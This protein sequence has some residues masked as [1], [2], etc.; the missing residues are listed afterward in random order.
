MN[1]FIY[2]L[3]GLIK[4]DAGRDWLIS[5]LRN[6]KVA[7]MDKFWDDTFARFLLTLHS[8]PFPK[9]GIILGKER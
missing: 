8:P 7:T 3:P 4:G 9:S 2:V 1:C 6:A 5:A